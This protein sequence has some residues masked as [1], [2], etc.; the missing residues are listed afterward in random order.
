MPIE[1]IGA[2]NALK[3]LTNFSPNL[4]AATEKRLYEALAPMVRK[5]RGYLPSRA[6]LS[7]W[8]NKG[9]SN[10]GHNYRRFPLYDAFAAKRGVDYTVSPSKPNRKGWSTLAAVYNSDPG[11]VIYETAGRKNPNG[12]KPAAKQWSYTQE[13]WIYDSSKKVSHSLN[14]NAGK[15]FIASLGS[16]YNAF[17]RAKGQRGRVSRKGKGRVIFRAWSEDGGK[18]ND[19]VL[20]AIQDATTQFYD[21]LRNK[22]A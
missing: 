22:V 21:Q 6:P 1:I 12:Q 20:S 16:L 9:Q 10:A 3:C 5:S 2:S 17:P 13:K 18:T 11:G 14:P 7:N 8:Q 15:Q 4:A 19:K